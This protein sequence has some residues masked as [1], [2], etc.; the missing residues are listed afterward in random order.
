MGKM[1]TAEA[2]QILG[3]PPDITLA[4]LNKAWRQIARK[5]HPDL[6][7]GNVDAEKQ[8]RRLTAAY[9][10]LLKIRE[11]IR[12]QRGL[13]EEMLDHEFERW[14]NT[15]SPK[16]QQRIRRELRDLKK[17]NDAK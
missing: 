3:V 16:H 9:D 14:L 10:T 1:S 12:R 6:F 15:L 7:P 5:T 8:Y 4:R 13:E 17:E 11:G 2:A